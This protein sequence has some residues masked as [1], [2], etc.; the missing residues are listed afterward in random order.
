[1]I[2][3]FIRIAVRN[4]RKNKIN[5]L[6][7]IFGL[8]VGM[9]VSILIMIYVYQETQFDDFNSKS[10]RIYRLTGQAWM[11]DGKQMSMAVTTGN[12]GD[13]L[14]ERIPEIEEA[15]T[16]YGFDTEEITFNHRRFTSDIVLWAD[17]GFLKIFDF[18]LLEGNPATALRDPYSVILTQETARKYF[19]DTAMNRE[20]KIN[21][22]KYKVTG[23]M[24]NVPDNS[25]LQM[26]MVASFRSLIR[27]DYNIVERNGIS[28]GLY[29]LVRPH[30]DMTQ[31]GEKFQ[32]VTQ[33]VITK[34]F[35]DYGI[36][37]IQH[38]QPL[39]KV[40]LYSR[41]NYDY[42][43][44]GDIRKVYIFSALAFFIILI[45]IMNFINLVT[46]QSDNRAKEIGIRKVSG[47]TRKNLVSQFIAESV[48]FSLFAMVIALFLNEVLVFPFS[49][50]MDQKFT[51]IYWDKPVFLA[52]IICFAI[53]V[54]IISGLYPAFFLSS[55]RPVITLK[56]GQFGHRSPHLLRKVL[57]T[58]QFSISIFLIVSL[59]LLQLQFRLIRER[60]L[61]FN[62]ENVVVF[63]NLTDGIRDSYPSI[64][65]EMLAR[66]GVL[67][68]TASQS[69]P[70]LNRS[71]QNLYKQGDDPTTA[72]MVHENRV[73][74]EYIKTMGMHIIRG[75]DFDPALKTDTAS[76]IINQTAAE[77][78]GLTDPIGQKLVVWNMKGTVVGIVSD[79]NFLSLHNEI[80]PLV[81]T[82]YEN[83]F[84]RISIR[85]RPGDQKNDLDRLSEILSKA[86]PSYNPD[87]TFLNNDLDDLYTKDER[88]NR[89]I[90][91]GAALA[92][93]ISILG[94]YG[95][96]AFTVRKKVKE[97]GIRKALGGS[98]G[99]ITLMLFRDLSR[100][101]LV[102]NLIA[103][104]LA[105]F[106][107]RDWLENFAFRIGILQQWWAFIA[108]GLLTLIVGGLTML[109]Q[110]LR[111]ANANPVDSLRYE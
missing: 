5:S 44:T 39:N 105:Y 89:M 73:Q 8:S 36:K 29:L 20:I 69:V 34:R 3:D 15:V 100:W 57:V 63:K 25:H 95:L 37:V 64:K 81:F 7:N 90:T 27:P 4:I 46:A 79:F 9:S 43:I 110:T 31:F 97:I 47:A 66:P 49:Q 61:G 93:L 35:G 103:W 50:V 38:L 108:A 14:L 52:G 80:D 91:M 58:L 11:A 72:I 6:I 16:C 75:R 76:F 40:H 68:V 2:R 70:G 77:K 48:L 94:L 71:V 84:N 26:D 82:H 51:L 111:A 101:V 22:V 99:G 92:I 33:D 1:M 109:Y 41:F 60:N 21:D 98:V 42:A 55:F 87:F 30:V 10:D 17:T 54:G 56:G 13:R 106:L 12:M 45:A 28:F 53:V 67:N 107:I 88:F 23:I 19:G 59:F 78:L 83:W 74:D 85:L 65:A 96:T 18:P 104:P 24:K 86:D 102:G 62:K 32:A